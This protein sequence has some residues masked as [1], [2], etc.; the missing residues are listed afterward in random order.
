MIVRRLLVLSLTLAAA[1]MHGSEASNVEEARVPAAFQAMGSVLA[2]AEHYQDLLIDALDQATP[3]ADRISAA[4]AAGQDLWR[5]ARERVQESRQLDDRQLYWGRLAAK[6]RFRERCSDP[7]V[8]APALSAFESAS[9]GLYGLRF[10]SHT[11]VRVV[12]SGFDP[13]QLDGDIEQS[14]PSGVAALRL[15]DSVLHVDGGSA[16]IQAVVVPVRYADFDAGMVEAIFEPLIVSKAIHM[17]VTISM[18]RSQFDL[19]RFPGR[20]RSATAPDNLNVYS[21]AS[22]D[23]P[24]VPRLGAELLPGPEFVEFSLPARAMQ[25]REGWYQV[26][27]NRTVTSIERGEFQ[28]TS[29]QELFSQTAVRGGGGGYLSNEI[30]FRTV[31]LVRAHDSEIIVGHIHTPSISGYE[32]EKLREITEQIIRMLKAAVATIST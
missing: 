9:R 20:R 7:K 27:D 26:N 17:L 31:R 24:L 3:D 32:P 1:P 25:N 21:G 22:S 12:I 13:F 18:G 8:C 5:L 16:E 14:N 19:E 10:Q 2:P 4:R 30:S 28:A 6:R 29:L 15:D 11:E 23:K